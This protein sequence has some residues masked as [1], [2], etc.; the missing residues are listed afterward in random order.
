MKRRPG[1]LQELTGR[2]ARQGFRPEVHVT[3]GPGDASRAAAQA[4][5]SGRIDAVVAVGGDGTVHEIVNGVAGSP[6]PFAVLPTGTMNILAREIGLPLDPLRAADQFADLAPRP[7]TAG[8]LGD[9]RYFLLMAG[10][11]FDAYALAIAL[12]RAGT[13]KVTMAGY[14]VSA[15]AAGRRFGFGGLDVECE[16][17]RWRGTSAIVGNTPRYGGNLR[18]TPRASLVDPFLDLCLLQG[19][20]LRS[21]LSVFRD[22]VLAGRHTRRRDVVYRKAS[23]IVLTPAAGPN[24]EGGARPT[25]RSLLQLDGEQAGELT[26]PLV[27][28]ARPAAVTLLVPPGYRASGPS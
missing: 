2:L 26:G 8:R 28:E 17:E 5:L 25:V 19:E 7:V 1:L 13:G 20:S 14:T 16:G 10:V 4:V 9:G 3:T 11:G 12:R 15:L 24:A 18:I 6:L 23:R 22:V 27:I 21:Y